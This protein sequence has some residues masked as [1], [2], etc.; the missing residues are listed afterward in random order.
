[1][2]APNNK[3][4]VSERLVHTTKSGTSKSTMKKLLATI[5]LAI[6]TGVVAQAA[7]IG[8]SVFAFVS[9]ENR[10][11]LAVSNDPQEVTHIVL[12]SGVWEVSG[13]VN[14]LSLST[15][16]GTMFTAANIAV[17]TLSFNPPETASVTAEQVAR[18]G[19]IIRNTAMVPRTIQV[20][21]GTNV[22]LVGGSFNPNPSVTAWGF[23]TAVKIRNNVD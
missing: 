23:I 15:P 11:Q 9:V 4:T 8:D 16:A 2:I 14:F 5:A 13:Q 17:G 3:K 1:V 12:D 18:L 21:D 22:F 10:V 19:N 20:G 6:S 7:Q